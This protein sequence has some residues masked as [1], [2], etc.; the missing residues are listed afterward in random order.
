M[1]FKRI[2]V[3]CHFSSGSNLTK[4]LIG[5]GMCFAGDGKKN[6]NIE[7]TLV[8]ASISAINNSDFRILSVLTNWIGV[9]FTRINVDR[10][11]RVLKTIS[12]D[13]VLCYWSAVS[14]WLA[15]DRR[16]IRLQKLYDG[17]ILDLLE[18]GSDFQISR[19][20][21]D[22]RFVGSK[23]R[24]P[25]NLLTIKKSDILQ[26]S[27]LSKL[28]DAYKYRIIQGPTY[29]ADMWA[30]LDH[31][32]EISIAELARQTYGSF[33]TAWKVKHDWNILNNAAA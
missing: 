26:P 19:Y 27:Q 20:G 16:F 13:K 33:A 14:Y 24:V 1:T 22:K 8:A 28:H 11:F 5:I 12:E 30:L 10:L 31:F 7:D 9:H 23:L 2:F 17:K 6:P 21:E 4:A 15:Q 32:P 3:P 29:R 25:S 18:T